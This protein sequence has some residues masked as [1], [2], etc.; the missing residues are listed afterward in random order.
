MTI[1]FIFISLLSDN[2]DRYSDNNDRQTMW[3]TS[4]APLMTKQANTIRYLLQWFPALFNAL[5]L[6]FIALYFLMHIN[7]LNAKE[8]K[9]ARLIYIYIYILVGQFL[10][11]VHHIYIYIYVYIY[12]TE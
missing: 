5:L 4:V 12:N 1:L 10:I 3:K 6:I 9:I 11:L 8:F 2:N 7:W